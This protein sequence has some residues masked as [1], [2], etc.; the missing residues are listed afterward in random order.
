MLES[1]ASVGGDLVDFWT[2][3]FAY[4]GGLSPQGFVRVFWAYVFLE[5]P[6]YLV[7]DLCIAYRLARERRGSKGPRPGARPLVSVVLPALN[8]EETIA[9]T[10][11]SVREQDYP[12]IEIVV[13]DDGSSD[14]TPAI[15]EALA[16]QGLI[17]YFPL[18]ERQGKAAALNYGSRVARGDLIV[19]MDTDSSLD[20]DAISNMHERLGNEQV[21]AVSGGLG[22]RNFRANVLTRLQAIEYLV[23]I[24][25]GRSFR[26]S[27]GILGIV[28][29]A[30]GM[31][32]RELLDRVG[33]HEP[34]PGNDSDLTI[35]VRKLHRQI[36]FASDAT[37]LTNAPERWRPWLRQRMRWDRNIVRNRVRRHRDTYDVRAAHFSVRNLL[38]FADTVFFGLILSLV[39]LGYVVDVLVTRPGYSL[40]VLAIGLTFHFLLKVLQFSIALAISNRRSEY[41]GLALYLPVFELYRVLQR[42]VRIFAT[43]QELLFRSS[44]RDPFAPRKVQ[45][46]MDVY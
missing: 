37:C 10:I 5:V 28:P 45:L 32:R 22:V 17:R 33:L 43:L 31:F 27:A 18:R 11:R 36:A 6:R 16:R 1:I 29:G 12:D 24:T 8:E 26:G 19:Y 7:T 2:S 23:S 40:H 42:L 14:R 41:A 13:V 21:G 39:W 46:E 4:A 34:G 25:V 35:R 3:A 38:S 30:F 15:C 20:R 44:Y 9:D